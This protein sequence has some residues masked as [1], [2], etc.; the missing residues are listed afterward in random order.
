MKHTVEKEEK[1]RPIDADTAVD[2]SQHNLLLH[3]HDILRK[4]SH[5]IEENEH[6][7]R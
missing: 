1:V 4:V 3:I 5:H 7:H 6:L 2:V